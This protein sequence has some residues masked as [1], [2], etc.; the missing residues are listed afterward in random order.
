VSFFQR[1][2]VATFDATAMGMFAFAATGGRFGGAL[3][4]LVFWGSAAA[5]AV[6]ALVVAA[7]GPA[8][9][10]WI[11]IGYILFAGVLAVEPPHLVVASLAFALMPVVP[12]PRGSLGIGLAI[13]LASA[14]LARTALVAPIWS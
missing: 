9:L 1:T 3:A 11:A 7:R 8:T 5:A 6:A 2:L 13:S 14:L 10:A 4:D 12:R